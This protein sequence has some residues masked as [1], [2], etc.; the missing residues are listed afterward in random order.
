MRAHRDDTSWDDVPS[1]RSRVLLECPAGSSPQ[2]IADAIE[3]HGYAVKVCEGPSRR[4][5]CDLVDAGACA[6]VD[7]ADV[8]VNLLNGPD[9]EGR[10]VIHHLTRLRRPPEVVTELTQPEIDRLSATGEWTFDR[11]RVEIVASPL[12][13]DALLEA[14]DAAMSR[15]SRGTPVHIDAHL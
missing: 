1:D 7:G 12:T 9:A 15:A 5:P 13:G 10:E 6:L 11:D 8:V 3:R 4:H 2:L 14:I